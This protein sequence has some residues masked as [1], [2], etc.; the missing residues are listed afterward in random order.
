MKHKHFWNGRQKECKGKEELEHLVGHNMARVVS[1]KQLD[2][3]KCEAKKVLIDKKVVDEKK[4]TTFI[5]V[6]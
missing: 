5:N 1:K 2:F 3:R 6:L 4:V